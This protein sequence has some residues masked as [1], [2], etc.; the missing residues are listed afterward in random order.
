[1]RLQKQIASWLLTLGLLVLPFIVWSQRQDVFDWW[2]LRNYAPPAEIQKLADQTTMND[3]SRRLFYVYHPELDDKQSFNGHCKDSE[4][5]IVLGCY[6]S[7]TGIYIYNVQDPR[8]SGVQ[9]VTAAHEMLHAAYDRLPSNERAKL[10]KQ[11]VDYFNSLNSE[12]LKKTIE[13]YRKKD[14]NVVP[15]ELHSILGTEVRTL[16]PELEQYYKRYF[17]DRASIVTFSEK[18]EQAFTEIKSR[19]EK[20]DAELAALKSRIESLQKELDDEHT[21]L[22]NE[23]SR[24]NVL[25][26]TNRTE[27]YNAGVPGYNAMVQQ[28]NTNVV[29]AQN[30]IDRFNRLVSE[31]NALALEENEL[32][33]AIDS[34][35]TT[36]QTK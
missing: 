7:N 13:A 32:V 4:S 34:R 21:Q 8:L 2:R 15:N 6:V 27:E 1:M 16:P 24:L 30:L 29:T 17:N 5:S 31:R 11:L 25:L 18:Y 20:Y 28:Y 14:P 22:T 26:E 19:V 9:E 10:D 33:K 3:Y 23:R 35:P 12:R 36:I